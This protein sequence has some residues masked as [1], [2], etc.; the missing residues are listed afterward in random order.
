MK[1]LYDFPIFVLIERLE[2]FSWDKIVVDNRV[3]FEI[4]LSPFFTI[5]EFH[6]ITMKTLVL[7]LVLRM[8]L[9]GRVEIL[10]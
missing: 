4:G 9:V 6:V 1:Y 5:H 3:V 8:D 7:S 10:V 2:L